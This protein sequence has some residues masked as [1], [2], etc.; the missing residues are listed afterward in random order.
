MKRSACCARARVSVWHRWWCVLTRPGVTTA[1]REVDALVR[2]GLLATPGAR[3]EPVLDQQPAVLVLRP[4]VVA[5]DDPAACVERLH[6][7]SGTSSKRSTSTSPRSVIF[8]DGITESPRNESV[9]NG[10]APV[11]PSSRAASLQARLWAMTSSSA[12]V[13]EQPG[14]RERALGE[15]ALVLHRDD[16]AADLREP[17]DREGHVLVGRA[18]DDEVVGVVRDRGRERAPLQARAGDEAECRFA[19]SRDA[20]RRRRSSRAR[21]RPPSR[22]SDSVTT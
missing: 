10:V 19:P 15:H 6:A 5:G 14:D 13:R 1:P 20:A 17:L 18:H 8:S 11:Q 21:D 22:T 3:D 7:S 16:A 12:R 2:L 9:R 4:R